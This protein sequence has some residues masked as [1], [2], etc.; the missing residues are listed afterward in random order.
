MQKLADAIETDDYQTILTLLKNKN[1][2][3]NCYASRASYTPLHMAIEHNKPELVLLFLQMGAN[4]NARCDQGLAI[5]MACK[6]GNPQIV[7]HLINDSR[8]SVEERSINVEENKTTIG[9][10]SESGVHKKCYSLQGDKVIK[11]ANVNSSYK[12]EEEY[13][14][15]VS[16]RIIQFS[17]DINHGNVEGIKSF[18]YSGLYEDRVHNSFQ[19]VLEL[20]CFD[21][22]DLMLKEGIYMSD[23]MPKKSTS[24]LIKER[25]KLEQQKQ[26]D[27]MQAYV[28]QRKTPLFYQQEIAKIITQYES[29]LKNLVTQIEDTEKKL[30][31]KIDELEEYGSNLNL[32]KGDRVCQCAKEIRDHVTNY[33]KNDSNKKDISIELTKLLSDSKKTMGKDRKFL[34]KIGH[35]ALLFT[36]IGALVMV[37]HKFLTGTFFLNQ[38][39]RG[40]LLDNI[41]D[42]IKTIMTKPKL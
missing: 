27:L 12:T 19:K 24:P 4:P 23:E 30:F 38:T 25:I 28:K 20:G 5:D 40:K 9:Y 8:L 3:I 37:G 10:L 18:L 26:I 15:Y 6:N 21:T 14:N 13:A 7:Q 11:E 32:A 42:E 1:M 39:K 36:G 22:V 35:I 29:S 41:N 31:K 2:D 16:G 34:D 17:E 33:L